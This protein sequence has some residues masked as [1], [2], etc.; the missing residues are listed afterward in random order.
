MS[1]KQRIIVSVT[2]IFL[3]LLILVGLTY[4]YFLTKIK[5]N[6]NNKSISVTT[7]NLLLEYA[8]VNDELI[9]DSAVEPGKT[10]TKTFVATNKGNKTVTYGVALENVVNT[11]ER[12]DDLVYTL[13]CKQYFKTG[14]SID[15]TNKTVT[16]TISGTC[17]GVSE[18]TTFP[19]LGTILVENDIAD[20]KAQV[21]TLVVT[22]KETNTD[23]SVDMNKTFSAKANIVDPNNFKPYGINTL[24]TAIIDSAKIAASTSDATRTIYRDTPITTPGQQNSHKFYTDR[25]DETTSE[26]KMS[27]NKTVQGYYWTYGTG[28]T[29]DENTGRFTLTGVST[30]KYNDGTCNT[31]LVGK[32]LAYN[33]AEGNS[34][35]TNTTKTTTNLQ[36]IYKVTEAPASSTSTITMKVKKL[37]A[38]AYSLEK[39]LSKTQ[40]DY[41]DSYYFRGNVV[42]NFVNYA[43][44]CWRIVRIEGDGSIKLILASELSCSDT[45]VT[46]SSGFSTDGAAGVQGTQLFARYGYKNVVVG[47]NTYSVDDYINSAAD[48]TGNARTKLNAWLERKITKDSDKALLKNEDWCIGDRTTAYDYST[49]ALKTETTEELINAG[50]SFWYSAGKRIYNTKTPTLKCDGKKERDGEIDTNKVGMLTIDEIVFAGADGPSNSTYY[51]NKNAADGSNYW[52][53]LS[54]SRFIVGDSYVSTFLVDWSGSFY[55]SSDGILLSFALRAAVSLT[56]STKIISGDGTVNNAYTVG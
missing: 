22:Y 44:M 34:S 42:D 53:A 11:L 10:W 28:Y 48:T 54:L 13:D 6:E 49:Y 50:T 55:D 15:K 47:S 29:I 21:Y 4:A 7:A 18:E 46:T 38:T 25:V 2:G 32:Y 14:F 45:N 43:G 20:D 1:R 27:I 37:S 23:Q 26:S 51:L 35:S 39:T 5:G 19:S 9:T 36:N 3:V 52:W 30:C 56:S 24:A 16:G 12:K 33:W 31:T 41:G 17:N 8:D 40:D